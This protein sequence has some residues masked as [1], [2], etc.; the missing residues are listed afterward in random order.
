MLTGPLSTVIMHRSNS[1]SSSHI[2]N[3][4]ACAQCGVTNAQ[5]AV[6]SCNGP[7]AAIL[8]NTMYYI[9]MS[10]SH[11]P[12][13]VDKAVLSRRVGRCEKH[14]RPCGGTVLIVSPATV[15][16]DTLGPRFCHLSLHESWTMVV[17]I[18]RHGERLGLAR[19]PGSYAIHV[20][21][22]ASVAK[23]V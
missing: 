1:S 23:W 16:G 6:T 21:N 10:N 18:L 22:G 3:V 20:P 19:R 12:T 15:W 7:D 17:A 9:L 5:I 11:C 14:R 13:R 2:N 8:S 4:C